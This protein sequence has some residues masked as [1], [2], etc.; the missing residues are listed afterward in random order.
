MTPISVVII[1]TY[2]P[3]LQIQWVGK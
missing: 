1:T 2:I 3:H